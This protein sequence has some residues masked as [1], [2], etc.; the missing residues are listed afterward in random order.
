MILCAGASDE[1]VEL[2]QLQDASVRVAEYL[3]E[4]PPKSELKRRLHQAIAEVRAR[5]DRVRTE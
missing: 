2:L 3:T 5:L 1:R 4:L